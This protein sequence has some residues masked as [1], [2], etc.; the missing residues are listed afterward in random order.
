M[1]LAELLSDEAELL[2]VGG[3]TD[4]ILSEA[5]PNIRF[6][7]YCSDREKLFD[8]YRMASIHVS[9]S[10]EET[11]GMTFVEAALAGTRS[12]GFASTAIEETLQGVYGV[13]VKEFTAY[14]LRDA[15]ITIKREKKEKLSMKEIECVADRYSAMNMADKYL[16]LYEKIMRG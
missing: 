11:Y 14:A 8:L 9:A 15:I 7:R 4:E 1:K 3:V 13:G 12:V 6:Y 10:L 5:P 2:L 16:S